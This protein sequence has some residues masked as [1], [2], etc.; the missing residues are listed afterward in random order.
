MTT[1]CIGLT[2][3]AWMAI[4]CSGGGGQESPFYGGEHA[5]GDYG[6]GDYGGGTSTSAATTTTVNPDCVGAVPQY[7]DVV[8]FDKC[9]TCHDSMKGMGQRKSAPIAVNFD[10][11]A[12]AESH[13]MQAVNMVRAGVMP[14]SPSGLTLS[15]SEK[16]QLYLWAMCSM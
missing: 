1:R 11:K 4:G 8:A 12:A 2:L 6:G 14:P 9:V 15:E 16:Q 7:E 5:S 13:A 3:L 10:T